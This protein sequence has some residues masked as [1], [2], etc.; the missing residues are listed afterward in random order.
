MSF[1][2]AHIETY[3][4]KPTASRRTP[5]QFNSCAQVFGEACR[6]PVYSQHVEKPQDPIIILRGG[7]IHPRAL[8]ARHNE[9]LAS[10]KVEAISKNGMTY[11]R[12]LKSDAKTLYTEIHSNPATPEEYLRDPQI[13]A[14]VDKWLNLVLKNF[15]QRMPSDIPFSVVI[16][17][18]ESHVHCHIL[19]V[20]INDP[21]L[22]ANKLHVGRAAAAR[23]RSE[24]TPFETVTSLPK[25]KRPLFPRKPRKPQ[26]CKAEVFNAQNQ[27]TYQKKIAAWNQSCAFIRAAHEAVLKQWREANRAHVKHCRVQR[28]SHCA[29]KKA[30]SDA[31]IRFQ[32]EYYEA[33][34]KP[35]GLQRIGPRAQRLST[36]EMAARKKDAQRR[37]REDA[38]LQSKRGAL[39]KEK[40]G[41]KQLHQTLME[42]A[43]DLDGKYSILQSYEQEFE[44]AIE[45]MRDAMVKFSQPDQDI[46]KIELCAYAYE[47]YNLA[48]KDRNKFQAMVTDFIDDLIDKRNQ[49]GKSDAGYWNSRPSYRR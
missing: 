23:H 46:S 19:A 36:T 31:L 38:E 18:D 47:A 15:V 37:K 10:L 8:E 42:Q 11:F 30:Y 13:K 39:A 21:K 49:S 35:C 26:P 25:P 5:K 29:E 9:L 44:M 2:F 41:L 43:S 22:D 14:D 20:N 34:G 40:E 12:Q 48:V 28:S 16:H 27:E 33:V 45:A 17:L 1:Q 4:Q 24:N 3:S 7:A 32:D 6:T